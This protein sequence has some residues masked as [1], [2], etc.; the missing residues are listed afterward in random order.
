M[1]ETYLT[2]KGLFSEEWKRQ[3]AAA[4]KR[5]LDDAVEAAAR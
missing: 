2:R 5:E 3:V 4:F 1:M